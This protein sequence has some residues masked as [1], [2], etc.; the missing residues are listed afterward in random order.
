MKRIREGIYQIVSPFPEYR[1]DEV[2][3]MRHDMEAHPRV[4]RCLPYVPRTTS[5]AGG[6]RCLWTAAG[7]RTTRSTR[8]MSS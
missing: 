7:I 6:T 1:K 2:Y 5:R 4:T 3:Q 8:W